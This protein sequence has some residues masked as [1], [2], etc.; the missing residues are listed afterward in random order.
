M[1]E[2][3]LLPLNLLPLDIEI[4]FNP[5]ALYCSNT[6]IP[7]TYTITQFNL[8]SHMIFFE[9]EIHRT[10]EASVA[11]HGLFI[12]CNGFHNAPTQLLGT[13]SL[14]AVSHISMNLKSI[15]SVHVLFL[16]N[17]FETKTTARKL[18]FVSHNIQSLQLLNGTTLIPQY[19]IEGEAGSSNEGQHIPYIV[20]LY[21]AWN[22]MHDP[23]TD[24]AIHAW[25][26]CGDEYAG[27]FD[28]IDL[29][30]RN[31]SE[32]SYTLANIC[33]K[34]GLVGRCQ[35]GI[36]LEG[37]ELGTDRTMITGRKSQYPFLL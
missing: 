21:K 30:W 18:H 15:N 27:Q 6:S 28:P 24:G 14:P 20:E 19:A 8:Y 33:N 1:P 9:Q 37:E 34:Q 11:D 32:V 23:R 16:Y 13:K 4:V 31:T 2:K 29:Y 36:S 7:R 5:H 22:K 17:H 26:W 35:Y 3:K 12:Y 10:L 25:N